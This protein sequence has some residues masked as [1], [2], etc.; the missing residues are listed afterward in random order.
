MLCRDWLLTTLKHWRHT[1]S[2]HLSAWRLSNYVPVKQNF[3]GNICIRDASKKK[4]VRTMKKKFASPIS[5]NRL[6]RVTHVSIDLFICFKYIFNW[7]HVIFCLE[8]EVGTSESSESN[9]TE[10]LGVF[11]ISDRIFRLV[12]VGVPSECKLHEWSFDRW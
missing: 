10:S 2:T 3:V 7:I 8:K 9:H 1:C 4:P 11:R 5:P 6:T 12:S